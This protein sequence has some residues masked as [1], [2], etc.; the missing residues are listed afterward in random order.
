MKDK[1]CLQSY[2]PGRFGA[3]VEDRSVL[4]VL[5][6]QQD[7]LRMFAVNI[8][9]AVHDLV[10]RLMII[11]SFVAAYGGTVPYC[12]GRRGLPTPAH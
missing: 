4:D 8:W 1:E 3:S 6:S 2:C 5:R 10:G 11:Q 12:Y 9:L 7:N